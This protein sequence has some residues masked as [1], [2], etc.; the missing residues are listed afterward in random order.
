[1]MFTIDTYNLVR[2][3]FM[4]LRYR[5]SGRPQCCIAYAYEPAQLDIIMCF[6]MIDEL[7]AIETIALLNRMQLCDFYT[8]TE[9][10]CDAK[11]RLSRQRRMDWWAVLS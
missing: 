11:K 1:M 2:L 8:T 6:S 9:P 10:D 5:V 4:F 3:V 7:L